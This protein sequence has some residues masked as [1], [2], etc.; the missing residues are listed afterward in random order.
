MDSTGCVIWS[1]DADERKSQQELYGS[2]PMQ[3]E[4]YDLKSAIHSLGWQSAAGVSCI[5]SRML[6]YIFEDDD[7]SVE[8]VLLP[9]AN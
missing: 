5:S 9:F 1:E 7:V 2:A 6:R 3:L 4:A 8:N